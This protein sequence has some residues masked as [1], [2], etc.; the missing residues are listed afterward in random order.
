MKRLR[1]KNDRRTRAA[2][3]VPK[4]AEVPGA[5]LKISIGWKVES[6]AS[7]EVAKHVLLVFGIILVA[8]GFR[9][10]SMER[11]VMPGGGIPLP[12]H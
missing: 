3:L 6:A 12:A 10:H 5:N 1:H 7:V 2:G 4:L 8:L 9:L 11:R